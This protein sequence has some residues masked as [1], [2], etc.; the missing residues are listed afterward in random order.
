VHLAGASRKKP[1]IAG[2]VLPEDE[3]TA[4][5]GPATKC[6]AVCQE[7]V[8]IFNTGFEVVASEKSRNA[9][10]GRITRGVI[11]DEPAVAAR[12]DA[13]RLVDH[14]RIERRLCGPGEIVLVASEPSQ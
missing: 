14:Q 5:E 2:I 4:A 13:S 7:I 9:E 8:F 6:R 1:D 10:T 3:A 11:P 12:P